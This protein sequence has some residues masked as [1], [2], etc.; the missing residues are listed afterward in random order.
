MIIG[1][2]PQSM[3]GNL[4]IG[5]AAAFIADRQ[6]AGFNALLVDLLCVKY[7]GCN[8]DGT[9][10]DGIEPFETPGDL[11]TPNPAYFARASAMIKLAANAGIVVFLDPIETGGWLGVLQQNGAQKDFAFGQFLG[12]TFGRFPNIVWSNGNDF[13]TWGNPADDAVVLAVARG[14]QSVD[15]ANIQT[16]ELNYLTSASLD[17]PRWSPIVKIDAAYTYSPTYAEVLKEYDRANFVPV[18]L[19]EAGYEFE[20]DTPQIS[21]GDPETLR[22]QEYW[23]IL[24]GATGQFYGNHYTWSFDD[25]WQAHLDTPGSKQIGYLAKLFADREWFQLVPDQAHRIVTAGYG[26][27]SSSGDVD[28]NNYVTTASTPDGT[29]AISY[30]PDGGTITVNMRRL[31]GP[32]E[33]QWYDPTNGRYTAVSAT[34]LPNSGTRRFTAPATNAGGDPDWVLVLTAQRTSA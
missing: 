10:Y 31:A 33:A 28:S 14:I 12:R 6:K 5:D 9:T 34:P 24:A 26:T 30:L 2:S 16:I 4:S 18:F 29:L 3:I 32:A 15:P 23:S 19:I 22:R 20:Q 25:G 7:T 1:D 17:D 13:Q 11:S 27:F 8:S 21:Y